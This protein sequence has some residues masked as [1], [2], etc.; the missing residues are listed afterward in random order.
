MATIHDVAARAGVSVT[1]VSRVMND[2]GYISEATRAKVRRA[3]DELGYEPSEIARSLL[4]KQSHVFGLIV[5]T[6]A[7]PF[8]GELTH[9]VEAAACERGYK[10]MLC[11]SGFDA[12]KERELLGLLAR[13]R[14]DG[15]ILGSHE[16][17]VEEYRK[18]KAPMASFDR[19]LSPDIP[20]FTSDNEQ[21]GRL[22]AEHLIERGCSRLIMVSG[23]YKP[24]MFTAGRASGFLQ[25]ARAA[26]VQA[27]IVETVGDALDETGYPKLMARVLKQHP[28]A[29]GL[30]FTSDLMA[31]YALR[32]CAEAGWRVP[33]RIKLVGY[34]DS[35][36]SRWL[37]PGLTTIRQPLADMAALAVDC[38]VRQLEGIPL[39][40]AR[41]LPVT[42]VQRGTT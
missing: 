5:P 12:S 36:V 42:L 20:W 11:H 21:G 15:I 8:F 18:L 22:A 1:T 25:A 13:N 31:A 30:F 33:E 6:T 40:P 29:D 35:G 7:H 23:R 28:R 41:P 14:V 27:D 17:D 19:R 34:D 2:R 3:M 38:L 32:A 16:L 37:Q 9:H 39:E 4:R 26:G 10:L 24:D